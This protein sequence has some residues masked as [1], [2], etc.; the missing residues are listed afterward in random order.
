MVKKINRYTLNIFN[1]IYNIYL[2][3]IEKTKINLTKNYKQ[4]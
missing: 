4:Y 1:I 3:F 2:I